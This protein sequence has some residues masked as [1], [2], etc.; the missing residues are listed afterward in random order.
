MLIVAS[1][2]LSYRI[3]GVEHPNAS[4]IS[5]Y[6]GGGGSRVRAAHDKAFKGPL[7]RAP[8]DRGFDLI[9]Q[10]TVRHCGNGTC[11]AGRH[12]VKDDENRVAAQM[13]GD[14]VDQ[15]SDRNEIAA[16]SVGTSAAMYTTSQRETSL[17]TLLKRLRFRLAARNRSRSG[18][19]IGR[20]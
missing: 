12:L 5:G 15:S 14:A 4:R 8:T 19:R 2:A 18:S 11:K 9:G 3:C 10:P 1:S 17:G 16:S 7:D 6:R 20:S 13:T